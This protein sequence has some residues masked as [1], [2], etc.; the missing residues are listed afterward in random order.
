MSKSVGNGLVN[1]AVDTIVNHTTH[2]AVD[3]AASLVQIIPYVGSFAGMAIPVLGSAVLAGVDALQEQRFKNYMVPI[4]KKFP[5]LTKQYSNG[6]S[7]LNK[8]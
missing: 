1:S 2:I 5:N 3:K 7:I 8:R 4:Q 6:E